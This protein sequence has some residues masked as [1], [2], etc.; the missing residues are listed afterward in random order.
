MVKEKGATKGW[1]AVLHVLVERRR[2]WAVLACSSQT[3]TWKDCVILE[4]CRLPGRSRME[5]GPC[6]VN[7][8]D[9]IDSST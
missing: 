7:V 9:L 8:W 3:L 2:T 6:A 5:A 4:G 1:L